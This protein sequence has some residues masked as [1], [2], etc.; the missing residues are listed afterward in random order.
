MYF[1]TRKLCGDTLACIL[2]LLKVLDEASRKFVVS[3]IARGISYL[4]EKWIIHRDIRLGII[5]LTEDMDAKKG[6]IGIAIKYMY[7]M[8]RIEKASMTPNCLSSEPLIRMGI[9]FVL[10]YGHSELHCIKR[11]LNVILSTMCLILRSIR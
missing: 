9:R 2:K 1:I 10:R 6:D 7:T 5:F 3:E 11:L 4:H 8:E